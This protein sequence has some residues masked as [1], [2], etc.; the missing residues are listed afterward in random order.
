[1]TFLSVLAAW[2]FWSGDW[3]GEK[4]LPLCLFGA[5]GT[6]HALW[7]L[8]KLLA[9]TV[10]YILCNGIFFAL[11]KESLYFG[12]S[13][14]NHQMFT[15]EILE[16]TLCFLFTV[17]V[18]VRFD[19]RKLLPNLSWLCLAGSVWA[20]ISYSIDTARVGINFNSSL[21]STLTA[22]LF[23]FVF[24]RFGSLH[25]WWCW[26]ALLL[27]PLSVAYCQSVLG[28]I[29]MAIG[30]LGWCISERRGLAFRPKKWV[31][32]LTLLGFFVNFVSAAVLGPLFFRFSGRIEIWRATLE[33]LSVN[34]LKQVFGLGLGSFHV[35]GGIIGKDVYNATPG[36]FYVTMHNDI[37]QCYFELGLAGLLLVA[38]VYVKA[39]FLSFKEPWSAAFL[40]TLSVVSF[41]NFPH[42][43]ALDGLLIALVYMH[44][45]LKEGAD[46]LLKQDVNP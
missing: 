40:L 34:P 32:P 23:P 19:F 43:L 27:P 45:F 12:M 42:H 39:L 41:G 8:D 25:K 24:Y 17:A 11:S 9:V 26:P 16:S 35:W 22:L 7:R 13:Y 44:I 31:F 29:A 14:Q 36:Q 6:A 33:F 37:L 30:G 10:G 1:M 5:I 21:S 38:S 18:A 4:W 46:A 28:L 3:L 2:G 15:E 20:V